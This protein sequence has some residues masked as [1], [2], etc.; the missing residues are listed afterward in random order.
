MINNIENVHVPLHPC[1]RTVMLKV[2]LGILSSS[3]TINY[4][5]AQAQAT[6]YPCPAGT[7]STLA[8]SA[9]TVVTACL[10][11]S[12]GYLVTAL[13]TSSTNA[14]PSSGLKWYTHSN[15]HLGAT[16]ATDILRCRYIWYNHRWPNVMPTV[17]SWPV[18]VCSNCPSQ[19]YSRHFL[20]YCYMGCDL[21][22][23]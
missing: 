3:V 7:Y 10:A 13:A 2:H 6:C 22:C 18:V 5:T 23:K 9:I 8:N 11:C 21:G 12:P 14:G 16:D 17:P 20:H 19:C 1:K 4:I 15:P